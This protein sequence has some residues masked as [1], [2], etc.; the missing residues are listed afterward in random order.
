LAVEIHQDDHALLP[1]KLFRKT[2]GVSPATLEAYYPSRY[3]HGF[4][5]FLVSNAFDNYNRAVFS[6]VF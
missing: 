1:F 5:R 6:L 4:K 3:A 2:E